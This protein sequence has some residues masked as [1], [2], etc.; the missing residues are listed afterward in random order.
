[1]ANANENEN[2]AVWTTPDG[3]QVLLDLLTDAEP[4][5]GGPE[6]R[7]SVCDVQWFA[8]RVKARLVAEAEEIWAL[9][10]R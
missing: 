5:V 8:D 10:H 9:L 2:V 3:E 7:P 6:L 1:M 4:I